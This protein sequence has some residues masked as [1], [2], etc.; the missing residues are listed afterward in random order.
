MKLNSILSRDDVI[1]GLKGN[2]KKQ[3]LQDMV[4]Q[5]TAKEQ[6]FDRRMILDHLMERERLGCT[7]IGEGIAI[8][9]ARFKFPAEVKPAPL[10]CLALLHDPIDYRSHDDLP[11]DIVFMLL[12]P[13]NTG[14]E[15]LTALALASRLLRDKSRANRLRGCSNVD[16]AWVVLN[17]DIPSTSDAA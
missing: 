11:V 9:H 5:M 8:P 4:R 1:I 3:L 12:A 16:A 17:A 2:S 7:G 15:H 6:G 14:G 10:T 13:E